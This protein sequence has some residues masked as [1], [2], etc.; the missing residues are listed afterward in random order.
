MCDD[1]SLNPKINL[2]SPEQSQECRRLKFAIGSSEDGIWEYDI[3]NNQTYVS[4]RWLE[5]IGYDENEYESSIDSW[6]ELLHPDDRENALNVLFSS[7]INKISGA[8]VRYRVRHK[9][10]HWIWI[11]DRAK[12]LFDES[13][14]PIIVA[15]FRTDISRQVELET[16]NQ[17]LAAIVQHTAIEVYILDAET[18]SYL[19][20]ND[21]A[22]KALGYT[23]DELQQLTILDINPDLTIEQLDIFRQYLTTI[24]PVLT[25]VSHHKR[26]SGTIYP[27]QASIH[28]LTYQGRSTIVI[29]DTDIS[30]LTA[31]QEQLLHLATHDSLTMLPNR[32][33]FYDR[34]Q[35]AIKHNTR[36]QEKIAVLFVDLDHFKEINDSLGHPIGDQLLI[37]VAQRLQNVLRESDTIAR[38][39]GDE[40]NILLNGFTTPDILIEICEKLLRSFK[41]PFMVEEHLLY[42]AISIGIAIYPEDGH[43]AQTLL[44]NSDTAMY[45]AKEEGR[46][47]YQFYAHEMG[48]KA[49]ERVILENA[50][51]IA[52]KEQQFEVY[53]QPQINLIDE[54]WIGMEALIR[55]NHPTLGVVS[56]TTFI[57]LCEETGLIQEIDFFVL[58]SVVEQHVQW[59]LAGLDSPKTAINF[60]A[61]TLAN[62]YITKEVEAILT[63]HH[64]SP[65]CIAIEVTESHIMKNPQEVIQIL[66]EL[67]ALD[68]EISIDDFG[69][70]Y[71]SLSY[72][73]RFPIN[74]L[75]IDQSF[76]RDIPYDEDDMAI[77]KTIIGLGKNLKL[78]V[79]AEGVETTLQRDFLIENGC[80]QVQGYL[81]FKPLPAESITHY[82]ID[83][84]D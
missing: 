72:L 83:F 13:G 15:G 78:S 4:Q 59:Q 67:R 37:Q 36:N 69:T 66:E 18:L 26:K 82:L 55:W 51:R 42:T 29:F 23:L 39:G 11:Y 74:K 47:S 28:K 3:I 63:F 7:I 33:L 84:K 53:Y 21:G 17:E 45:R 68:L 57:P 10:G 79:I 52:L 49:Y 19:Y 44:K 38:M 80:T 56:P 34:L 50:L 46:N 6:K 54:S 61:K 22:L 8:H 12:I 40:F 77:T 14:E 70:G 62:R 32:V 76:I 27:V 43:D 1:A 41:D 24:A 30:E 71:S 48:E 35:M 73:K 65:R 60:S 75:K 5:I 81:Y 58:E 31:T 9:Q 25:D 2:L 16:H 64:C 20:A